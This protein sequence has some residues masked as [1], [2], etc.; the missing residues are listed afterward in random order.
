MLRGSG[1][2]LEL[3]GP[4]LG[5]LI[6]ATN[7]VLKGFKSLEATPTGDI[8]LVAIIERADAA[9]KNASAVLNAIADLEREYLEDQ[10][11]DENGR[12]RRNSPYA[13]LEGD[14]YGLQGAL[15]GARISVSEADKFANSRL[16]ILKA[17]AGT[18]K[19]HLLCDFASSRVAAGAPVI[20]LLGHR[21]TRI[22]R[23]V[24][25]GT[26]PHRDA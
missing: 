19:T 3:Q 25:P 8:P 18:G 13:Q 24:D 7:E 6:D 16:L 26:S 20:L 15:R 12:R 21:F 11:P 10:R 9:E 2:G 22:G 5:T 4:D 17:E 23:T 14:V 1:T